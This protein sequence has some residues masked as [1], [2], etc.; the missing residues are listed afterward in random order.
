MVYPCSKQVLCKEIGEHKFI[1]YELDYPA[2]KEDFLKYII[3]VL[4]E[5]YGLGITL[6]EKI[7]NISSNRKKNI[8]K[9]MAKYNTPDP[10]KLAPKEKPW[11]KNTRIKFPE[12]LARDILKTLEKVEFACRISLEEEDP[13]MPKRGIDNFGF[14]FKKHDGKISLDYIVSCEVKASD[15]KES[16]P[17]VVHKS[18]DSMFKSLKNIT[19][20]DKRFRKAIASLIDKLSEGE[21][22]ELVCSVACDL[23]KN[24]NLDGIRKKII[25]VPFLLRKKECWTEN[26]FGK[27]ATNHNEIECAAIRYYILTV[28]YDLGSFADEIYEELRKN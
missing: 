24:E 8:E 21:Y 14:I 15:D 13:D 3:P 22:L 11:L 2:K 4:K 12:V 25:A 7:R 10:K 9:F 28:N 6:E 26:D 1:T 16:P 20:L 27:F 23:E 18:S 5:E 17:S 19:L